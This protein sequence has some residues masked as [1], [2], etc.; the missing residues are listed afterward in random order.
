MTVPSPFIVSRVLRAP[1]QR[2]FD[3]YTQ[4][5][6]LARWLSPEG[7]RTIQTDMDFRIGGRYHYGIEGPNGLQMWGKQ[8][9]LE[10][11]PNEKI[12]HL[13]SFSTPE[14][15]LGTHPMAPTWPKYMHVTTTFEDA[16]HEGTLVTISW[17]PH[18]SDE[19]GHQ[20][21]DTARAGM[22][23]GWGGTFAKLEAYLQE[24]QA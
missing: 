21:F 3:I 2:V 17:V 7:F 9:Y 11:V 4:A 20:T 6:H 8:E 15:G 22:E 13:Q 23:A 16:P 5:Q 12:V 24:L 19:I 10:I 1:R 14:G 18:E